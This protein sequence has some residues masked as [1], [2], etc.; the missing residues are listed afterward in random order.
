M[1]NG[2]W[3]RNKPADYPLVNS[4]ILDCG[5]SFRVCN[6]LS[7]FKG[8]AK[9]TGLSSTIRL[10][11]ED[12]KA[13]KLATKMKHVDIHSHWLRQEVQESWPKSRLGL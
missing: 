4:T 8:F 12:Y 10:V 6:D 7:C 5:A 13:V 3:L 9:R 1:G 11:T 2:E